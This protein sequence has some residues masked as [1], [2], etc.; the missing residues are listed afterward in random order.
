MPSPFQA[1]LSDFRLEAWLTP[2]NEQLPNN[3]SQ[4]T[5]KYPSNSQLIP[6]GR[7]DQFRPMPKGAPSATLKDSKWEHT[8][9]SDGSTQQLNNPTTFKSC[10]QKK[11]RQ[12]GALPVNAVRK[13]REVRHNRACWQCWLLHLSVS[14]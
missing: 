9:V 1:I 3:V 12:K 4:T 8:V 6:Q 13:A 5:G 14:K 7:A 2:L 11:G 10:K